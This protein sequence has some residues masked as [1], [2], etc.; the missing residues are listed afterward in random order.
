MALLLNFRHNFP[1][2]T[3]SMFP[4][5]KSLLYNVTL[6]PS[7]RQKKEKRKR[8]AVNESP[9]KRGTHSAQKFKGSA[10]L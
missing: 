1:I 3:L 7:S 9:E 4:L 5:D 10:I 6:Y 8:S 2:I